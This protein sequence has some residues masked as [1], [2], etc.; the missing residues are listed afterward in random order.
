M[1]KRVGALSLSFI[2]LTASPAYAATLGPATTYEELSSLAASAADGDILLVSGVLDAS[3]QEALTSSSSIRI[4]SQSGEAAVISGLRLRDAKV[5]FTDI[6]LSDSLSVEGTSYIELAGGVSVTGASGGSGIA[7]DGNGSLLMERGVSV[8]G[9]ASSAGI[10]ISHR[11][12]DFYGGIDGIVRGGS[13]STGGPGLVVSPLESSGAMMISGAIYGGE[14]TDVGGHALGLFELSGNAYITVDGIIQG[15]SGSLG[16]DGIQLVSAGDQVSVGISGTV[17][18]GQGRNYGGNGM[19][20]MNAGGS[21][22]V[23]VSGSLG[24]GNATGESAQPGTSLIIA[25][26]SSSSHILLDDCLMTDGTL[27]SPTP[28]PTPEPPITPLPEITASAVEI[29]A[30]P[31]PPGETEQPEA[32]ASPDIVPTTLPTP[33]T[34]PS[35]DSATPSEAETTPT[36]SVATPAEAAQADAQQP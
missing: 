12:G 30:L 11:G 6:T 14:G 16:G 35:P 3:G 34:T 13:G 21:S 28:E 19:I 8:T 15:G 33:E 10:S 31:T 29:A 24:G 7:F 25:G 20:L 9:G 26:G 18:G 22:V 2:L 1:I 4:S 5:T 36:P 32:D 23:H 17:T 27:L